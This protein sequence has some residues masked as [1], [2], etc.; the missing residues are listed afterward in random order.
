MVKN[1]FLKSCLQCGCEHYI[2]PAQIKKGRGKYCS[3]KCKAAH[4]RT[5]VSGKKGKTYTHLQRADVRQCKCCGVNFRALGDHNGKQGGKKSRTPQAYCSHSCYVK[6]NRVSRFE[7][8]VFEYLSG[9]NG[10][11]VGQV[12][13]GRWTFD[14]AVSGTNILIEADGSYWHSNPIVKKRDERKDA[15]CEENHFDLYRIDELAFYKNRESACQIIID[16]MLKLDP[17]LEI[18]KNGQPYKS[19]NVADLA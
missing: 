12:K 3:I 1:G 6:G 9:I 17:N 10:E 7:E 18:K 5:L 16:R 8:T 14:M 2:I 19:P 4:Q 13:K 11:I 15:W